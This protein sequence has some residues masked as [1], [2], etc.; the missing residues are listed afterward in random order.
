MGKEH[1]RLTEPRAH[2]AWTI[3][4]AS[5]KLQLETGLKRRTAV[6]LVSKQD[7]RL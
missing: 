3:K 2:R 6:V 1:T 5:K 4:Q 7:V